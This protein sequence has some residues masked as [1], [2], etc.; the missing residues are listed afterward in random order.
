MKN[1]RERIRSEVKQLCVRANTILRKDVFKFLKEARLK[2]N[3]EMGKKC[4]DVLITNAEIA[5]KNKT[6]ICQDTG[7]VSV[8][9]ELP[10]KFPL[11]K[12]I[13]NLVDEAVS[14]A[15]A[16]NGFRTSIVDSP[17]GN[18]KLRKDNTP[19]FIN[20]S[21]GLEDKLRITVMPKGAGSENASFLKMFSPSV[22]TEEVI[23]YL[24]DELGKKVPFSCPPVIVGIG[25][26]ATF[27]KVS[28]LARKAL[29]RN[30]GEHSRDAEV[31]RIEREILKRINNT[32][33]GPCALGGNITCLWV[34]IESA[35][36]HMASLPVAVNLSCHALRS[37]SAEIPLV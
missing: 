10:E 34:A 22:T 18:R 19:A 8:F 17:L 32:G 33:I 3:S 28:F 2:E 11:P 24:V 23:S 20:I 30:V 29:L 27:D 14:E 7:V 13:E 37:A 4:L 5:E 31:A 9:I 15:Y 1:L 6:P 25:V 26:G 35:P 36:T 12:N 16:E 21:P